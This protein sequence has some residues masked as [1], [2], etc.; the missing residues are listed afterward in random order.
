[1]SKLS[2]IIP[3]YYNAREI[4]ITLGRL[5][6]NEKHFP[7]STVIEYVMV[8]DGS[9]DDTYNELLKM[10]TMYP[11][12][13]KIIK[14]VQ[15]VGSYNAISAG[16]KYATGNCCT[17]ISA[18]LQ[19]P[20]EI[21]VRMYEFWQKG[22]KLVIANRQDR[23][24][25]LVAKFF[26]IVFQSLLKKYGLP[27]LPKGGYDFVLFDEE[28]KRQVLQMGEKN[29]NILYL[30]LWLGHE[31]VNIP[32]SRQERLIGKSRWTFSKKIK[33][34]IDS[35]V[36][37]S[38]FPI[39]LIS[40][41]G[42]LLGAGAFLYGIIIVIA[43]VEGSINVAGWTSMMLVFLLVSSFQMIALGIIG[44]YLWRTLDQVRHRPNYIVEKE[45]L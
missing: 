34:F 14:L 11:D 19:D 42:L 8:D 12:K 4:S 18:D 25:P 17:V 37:F 2:V 7:K 26:S 3:C 24:D 20:P 32:Y 31:Y 15:N 44:E 13:I 35:F 45:H 29:T 40:V 27:R 41:M 9:G 16:M 43:K 36:A 5:M 30:L 39:R 1:M 22:I 28:L 33:L 10:R 21:I 6:D 38:Y 23:N